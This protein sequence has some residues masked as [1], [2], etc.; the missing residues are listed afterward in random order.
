MKLSIPIIVS[1]FSFALAGN[2]S[3]KLKKEIPI[4]DVEFVEV[5]VSFG[6]GNLYISPGSNNILFHGEFNYSEYEPFVA[7]DK[8]HREGSLQIEMRED[9]KKEDRD[10]NVTINSL[11]EIGENEWDLYFSEEIQLS[12]DIEMG[13]AEAEIDFGAMKITDLKLESG[14]SKTRILFSKPNPIQMNKLDI[15]TGVSQFKIKNLLHANFDEMSFEGGIGDY[16]LHFGGELKKTVEVELDV[17]LGALNIYIPKNIAYRI[18]CD[19]SIFSS[20]NVEAAYKNDDDDCWYSMN[21]EQE[22]PFLNMWIE[23]G[24]GS[25]SVELVEE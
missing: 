25:V 9:S 8:N 24:I 16:E 17:A 7:Y 23:A 20:L 18:N 21:F 12:F 6:A 2:D 11:G 13:A 14:A 1:C 10:V 5:S 4:D 19:K 22:L 3:D 15:E